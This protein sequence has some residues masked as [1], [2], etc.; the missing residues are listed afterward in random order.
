MQNCVS[1]CRRERREAKSGNNT[2]VG[3]IVFLQI[4]EVYPDVPVSCRNI[5]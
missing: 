5:P 3:H 1:G 2:H 4:Y